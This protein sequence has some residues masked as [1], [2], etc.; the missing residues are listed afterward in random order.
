[1]IDRNHPVWGTAFEFL[2]ERLE[3]FFLPFDIIDLTRDDLQTIGAA[4]PGSSSDAGSR[5][6][7]DDFIHDLEVIISGYPK[8]AHVRLGLC[9]FKKDTA[10]YPIKNA[11]G[12]LNMIML[13]NRRVA[14]IVQY[15]VASGI[16]AS[17]FVFPWHNT[18][19]WG[20][21]R[22]FVYQASLVGVSQY[23]HGPIYEEIEQHCSE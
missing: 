13:P 12:A 4:T 2:P 23:R 5:G 18:P 22:L 14:S 19:I 15:Y 21:F 16:D 11:Q 7:T 1:M 6:F 3:R 8:G 10:L 9:S 17:L 20:E